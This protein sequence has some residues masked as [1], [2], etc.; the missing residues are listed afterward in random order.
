MQSI[1]GAFL[2]HDVAWLGM[3]PAELGRYRDGRIVAFMFHDRVG[4]T[5][6]P[7]PWPT[8]P[9]GLTTIVPLMSGPWI[10]QK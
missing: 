1:A 3:S 5:V 4:W 7:R 10:Q 2:P 8:E 9:H 6:V